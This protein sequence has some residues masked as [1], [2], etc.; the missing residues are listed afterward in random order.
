MNIC[1][2]INNNP[3]DVLTISVDKSLSVKEQCEYIH[4]KVL[5]F[6]K[7]EICNVTTY[8]KENTHKFIVTST[9]GTKYNISW[10]K[11]TI[12]TEEELAN[13]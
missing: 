6:T 8:I 5:A 3:T 4:D 9:T 2:L 13:L 1:I 7:A 12:W 11:V 10:K